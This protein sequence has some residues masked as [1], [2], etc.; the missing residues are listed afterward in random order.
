MTDL[1]MFDLIKQLVAPFGPSG[2]ESAAAETIETLCAPYAQCSRDALGNVIAHRPGTGKRILIAAHMDT[3]GLVATYVDDKGFV[4][5]GTLGGVNLAA[6][7]HQRVRFESG[8]LA[9][10][11]ADAGTELKDL[12]ADKCYLDPCGEPVRLGEVAVFTGETERVGD[13]VVSPYLDNRVGCAIAIE[14]LRQVAQANLDAD[15]YVAFTVQE[16]VGTR[17]AGVAAFG[18]APELAVAIDVTGAT[19]LPGCENEV[20]RVGGGPIVKLM[21]RSCLSHPAVTA[22]LERSAQAQDI[23]VQHQAATRGGTD[24]GA[25]SLSRGGVP[26]GNL[27]IANRCTHTPNE[28]CSLADAA[29]CAAVLTGL[30]RL[31]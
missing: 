9:V 10:V 13:L 25:I 21:D 18:V 7:L 3:L 30:V 23:A 27:A 8:A 6:A 26:T 24:A 14:T 17:G 15:L 4:R 20:T 16:E 11:R 31:A 1:L 22:L 5:F 29:Q 19:D 28:I 2:R 12:S